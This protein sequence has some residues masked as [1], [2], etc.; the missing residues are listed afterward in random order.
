MSLRIDV[1]EV[2]VGGRNKVRVGDTVKVK[3]SKPGKRDGF[4]ARVTRIYRVGEEVQLEVF[5]GRIDGKGRQVGVGMRTFTLDRITRR[6]Q[7]INGEKIERK[8]AG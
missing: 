3:P 4:D 1:Q 6:R 2:C 8:K 5:G 7:T